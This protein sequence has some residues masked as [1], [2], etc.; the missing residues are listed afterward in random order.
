[1][2]PEIDKCI[3]GCII[4]CI[5][6]AKIRKIWLENVK[7]FFQGHTTNDGKQQWEISLYD[8]FKDKDIIDNAL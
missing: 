3:L 5:G 2:S 8:L 6:T 1:M 7:Q 4:T